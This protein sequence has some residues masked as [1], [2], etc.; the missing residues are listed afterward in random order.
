MRRRA[1]F[2]LHCSAFA[3][4]TDDCLGRRRG[5][6]VSC[7]HRVLANDVARH[8]AQAAQSASDADPNVLLVTGDDTRHAVHQPQQAQPVRDRRSEVATDPRQRPH[9]RRRCRARLLHELRVDQLRDQRRPVSDRPP[10]NVHHAG[11]Q[12]DSSRSERHQ[13]PDYEGDSIY[14]I[15]KPP[16]TQTHWIW[17]RGLRNGS[18]TNLRHQIY[19]H[20]RP[21]AT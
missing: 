14:G 12:H 16:N 17:N 6:A 3:C 5:G 2:R 10:V 9:Q 4:T 13:L 18:P 7:L 11:H 8:A 15:V 1:A 20:G 21:A 19:V